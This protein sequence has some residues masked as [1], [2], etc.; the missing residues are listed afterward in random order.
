MSTKRESYERTKKEGKALKQRDRVLDLLKRVGPL[1]REEVAIIT[2]I[3]ISSACGRVNE[4]IK[5]KKVTVAGTKWNPGTQRNVE[6][7]QANF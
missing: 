3:R 7:V 4:L 1:S 6:T 2:R 5:E